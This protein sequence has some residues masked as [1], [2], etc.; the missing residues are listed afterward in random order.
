MRPPCELVQNEYL[1]L[2]RATVAKLLYEKNLSQTEI[3][4]RM[5]IT[6][7]AV[8]KYLRSDSRTNQTIYDVG[9]LSNRIAERLLSD[10]Y[11]SSKVLQE[12]CSGCMLSRVSSEICHR[13]SSTNIDLAEEKCQICSELLS[14]SNSVFTSRAR[15]VQDMKQSLVMLE[16]SSLFPDLMPQVRPNLVVCE[17]NSRTPQD[18]LAVPGR[19]TLVKGRARVLMHP[20]FGASRHT[21][22]LVL[23]AKRA[24]D[25]PRACL[26]LRGQDDIIKASES[27]GFATFRLDMACSDVA[28]ILAEIERIEPGD[29]SLI[30]I[31][32]PGGI[33]IEPILYAFGPSGVK[34]V[35]NV[36]RVADII[37][38]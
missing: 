15:I 11:S 23:G 29:S 27:S 6:Q 8:S 10:S 21:A 13:H 20:Q 30:A 35:T 17:K 37:S 36:L 16:Q 38:K 7:A 31:S 33:G 26:S 28:E 18:V 1:P 22:E 4:S 25:T 3:A 14:G 32:V 12:L 9:A 5:G 24:W 19:I 2:V 34:L